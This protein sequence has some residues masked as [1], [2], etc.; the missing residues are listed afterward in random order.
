[1]KIEWEKVGVMER[2]SDGEVEWWSAL[3]PKATP[4]EAPPGLSKVSL[5]LTFVG[6]SSCLR[7][8]PQ[9]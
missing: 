9:S 1:M 4:S 7:S 5:A 8:I 3:F 6:I 2:G